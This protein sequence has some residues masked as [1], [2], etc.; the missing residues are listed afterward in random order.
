M[1]QFFIFAAIN[2]EL[3][4]L[5]EVKQ[6]SV[7][8]PQTPGSFT[9]LVGSDRHSPSVSDF[10]RYAAS[11]SHDDYSQVECRYHFQTV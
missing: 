10:D 5:L 8:F 4:I 11:S 2:L 7:D 3:L 9:C 6:R 1:G